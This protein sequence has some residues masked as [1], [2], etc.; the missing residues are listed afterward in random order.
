MILNSRDGNIDLNA[1]VAPPATNFTLTGILQSIAAN[2]IR[3]GPDDMRMDKINYN[4]S[5]HERRCDTQEFNF[6]RALSKYPQVQS[7]AEKVADPDNPTKKYTLCIF[8]VAL[9][10][11]P[12]S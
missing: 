7:L 9:L 12:T 3:I 11:L 1:I 10:V 2:P 6:F 5:A 4:S 8:I